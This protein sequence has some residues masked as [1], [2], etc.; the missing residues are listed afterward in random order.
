MFKKILIVGV[1]AALLL[2]ASAYYYIFVYS[3]QHRRDVN[4]EDA[5]TLSTKTLSDA[6]LSNEQT[7]NQLYLNKVVE[8]K[9]A[10]VQIGEDQS[11]QKTVLLGSA[12]EMTNVFV[13]L[14]GKMVDFKVGDTILVRAICNGYLTDVVLAEGVIQR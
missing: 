2:A 12:L 4:Q 13:T 5:I 8:V 9:G 7:A 3:V 6:F 14:K 11:G 10:V 1:L